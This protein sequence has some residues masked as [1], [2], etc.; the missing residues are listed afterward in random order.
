M[1][2]EFSDRKKEI[3]ELL[4]ENS[5]LSVS[6]LADQLEVSAVTIRGDLSQLEDLG[7]LVRSRGGAV[8]AFHPAIMERK[9]KDREKKM[10]MAKIGASLVED[11]DTIM[12]CT[13]TSTALV[14]KYLFGR[15]NIH[16]VTNNTLILPYVRI[17]PSI[18]VTFIGGE[19]RA[20]EEGLIGP[21]ALRALEQ[22]HVSKVFIGVDG[23]SIKQ[24]LTA[25]LVETAELARKMAKQAEQV[26]VLADA[27]KFGYLGFARI[28]GLGGVHTLISDDELDRTFHSAL[29]DLKVRVLTPS[30][31]S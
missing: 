5:T 25:H 11:G 20:S 3:L 24:G 16:V 8:S 23:V 10:Q 6:Q 28:T 18:R 12:I 21:M 13:G 15:R 29:T 31:M 22:F 14:A 27:S 26:I 4:S 17:N 19:F 7:L 1:T 30:M 9:R 2:T